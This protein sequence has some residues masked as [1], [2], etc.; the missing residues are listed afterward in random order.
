MIPEQIFPTPED[1]VAKIQ[2]IPPNPHSIR[3]A[4]GSLAEALRTAPEDPDFDLATWEREWA[5]V[6]AEIKAMARAPL[7]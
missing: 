4:R 6:E 1:V 7:D 2:A 5:E 3:L